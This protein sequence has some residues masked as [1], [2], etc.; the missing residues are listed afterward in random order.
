[1]KSDAKDAGTSDFMSP[2]PVK[3]K[4]PKTSI[5]SS[6]KGCAITSSEYAGFISARRLITSFKFQ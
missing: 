1:M 4:I 5:E 6:R 2:L 3:P